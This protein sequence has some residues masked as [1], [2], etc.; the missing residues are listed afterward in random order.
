MGEKFRAA[1]VD[2]RI[3]RGFHSASTIVYAWTKFA[4]AHGAI[5]SD[6]SAHHGWHISDTCGAHAE[7]YVE[8]NRHCGECGLFSRRHHCIREFAIGRRSRACFDKPGYI[9]GIFGKT[10]RNI[11]FCG[12]FVGEASSGRWRR[13]SCPR[14]GAYRRVCFTKGGWHDATQGATGDDDEKEAKGGSG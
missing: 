6:S 3:S 12:V 8:Q 5:Q 2:S 4:P 1:S 13:C 14:S 10:N 9:C 7:P 11:V